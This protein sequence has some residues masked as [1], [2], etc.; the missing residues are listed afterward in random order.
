MCSFLYII[1]I[2]FAYKLFTKSFILKIM[3]IFVYVKINTS[4]DNDR[5]I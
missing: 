2:M 1:A 5:K 4:N 3:R